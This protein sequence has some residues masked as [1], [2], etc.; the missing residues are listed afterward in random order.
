MSAA[1]GGGD[2]LRSR[3][4]PE[5]QGRSSVVRAP[6]L[7]G[8]GTERGATELDAGGAHD[9]RPR[10]PPTSVLVEDRALA[11]HDQLTA[12]LPE[13]GNKTHQGPDRVP[14]G[15]AGNWKDEDPEGAPRSFKL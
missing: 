13:P 1:G 3:W 9:R 12:M 6:A 14:H 11:P 7:E 5:T 15:R 10:P 4:P 8:S 2:T